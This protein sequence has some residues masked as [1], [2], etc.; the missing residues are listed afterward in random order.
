MGI[1]PERGSSR[2]P[3]NSRPAAEALSSDQN[4]VLE[5]WLLGSLLASSWD[6]HGVCWLC[7][8]CDL[9]SEASPYFFALL[10]PLLWGWGTLGLE[11]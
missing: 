1:T 5:G 8:S 4:P 2:R 7:A 9:H 10:L 3:P 11:N 6:G